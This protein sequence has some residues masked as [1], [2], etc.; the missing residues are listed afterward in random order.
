MSTVPPRNNALLIPLIVVSLLAL[1]EAAVIIMLLLAPRGT[2]GPVVVAVPSPTAVASQNTASVQTPTRVADQPTI[3]AE[4]TSP[5][6][7]SDLPSGSVG[8]RVESAGVALTVLSVTDEPDAALSN[9]LDLAEDEKYLAT[10]VLLENNTGD[11]F[12]YGSAQF[13]LKDDR[14]FEYS[15]SLPYREPSMGFGT[16]VNR[17]KVR[18][19]LSFIVPTAATGLS[20][21]YQA[22]A[23]S[24]YETIYID[25]GQ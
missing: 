25:L 20:L 1:M 3:S 12:F 13:K 4:A 15:G 2:T 10:E 22:A 7:S 11:S 14:G 9:I 17:E 19:Y 24:D 18:G 5:P 6:E 16:L 21:I 8:D 23:G